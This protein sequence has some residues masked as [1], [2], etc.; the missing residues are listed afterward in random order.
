MP[1]S[2]ELVPNLG[3]MVR[4]A[5]RDMGM[6]HEDLGRKIR[7][8]VS[9]LR[10]IESDKMVPDLVLAEK[11]EHAL[12]IKL[13]VPPSEPKAQISSTNKPQGATLGDLISFNLNQEEAE[14]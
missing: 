5:R 1:K 12:K 7:E 6:S 14:K 2:L 4:Q 13:R 10:K 9:V 3:Q 8:R 11:L